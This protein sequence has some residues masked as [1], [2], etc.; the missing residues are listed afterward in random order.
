LFAHVQKITKKKWKHVTAND[1]QRLCGGIDELKATFS[2]LC[3]QTETSDDEEMAWG[4]EQE[5]DE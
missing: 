4:E 3:N 1:W 5:G 2:E